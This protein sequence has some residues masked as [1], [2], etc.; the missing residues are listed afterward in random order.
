MAGVLGACAA[1]QRAS[2]LEDYRLP[3]RGGALDQ[4]V[5]ESAREDDRL[6][7]SF[8]QTRFWLL[9]L[10]LYVKQFRLDENTDRAQ[11]TNLRW[12]DLST[13]VLLTFLPLR[14]HY[15][16]HYYT[17]GEEEPVGRLGFW[18]NPLWTGSNVDPAPGQERVPEIRAIGVPLLF[19]YIRA[20]AS[21]PADPLPGLTT[22]V[23]HFGGE[24]TVFTSLWTLGPAAVRVRQSDGMGGRGRDGGYAA[25]PL[26]LGGVLGTFLWSDYLFR[27]EREAMNG[28]AQAA[29]M[30][31]DLPSREDVRHAYLNTREQ[32]HFATG[33]G[34][35]FGFLGY[36]HTMRD[37]TLR[38]GDLRPEEI[39][40]DERYG[41]R[42]DRYL[43]GGILWRDF[44]RR[45]WDGEAV[46]T[47]HG[48]LWGFIGWGE[49]QGR[50]SPR[51]LWVSW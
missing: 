30:Y 6:V 9:P 46:Y 26:L 8:N 10:S 41:G 19:S 50:F 32:R 33:H 42:S 1:S 18:W 37:F 40:L 31:D 21:P 36:H 44:I 45:D 12:N 14:V 23:T 43:L 11:A 3:T 39:D 16:E 29:E 38:E 15:S 27:A 47:G 48:P 51:F 2:S 28:A 34:P 4:E 17:E 7:H 49:R 35:V 5:W 25:A 20:T 24:V 22:E 13:P